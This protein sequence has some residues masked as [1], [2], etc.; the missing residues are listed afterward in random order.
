MAG[1]VFELHD[2]DAVPLR[3]AEEIV[4]VTYDGQELRLAIRYSRSAA[5]LPVLIAKTASLLESA[6]LTLICLALIPFL[7]LVVGL[8]SYF[9]PTATYRCSG[10]S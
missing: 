1:L 2:L 8:E 7:A 9:F 6:F 10:R 4:G 5:A 3:Q